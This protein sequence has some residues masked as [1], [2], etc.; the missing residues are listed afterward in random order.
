MSDGVDT[1]SQSLGVPNKGTATATFRIYARIP[2]QQN[3]GI[4]AYSDRVQVTLT[5]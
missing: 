4:G 1:V 2:P 3:V 5:Y